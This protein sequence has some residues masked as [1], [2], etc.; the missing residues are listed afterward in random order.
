MTTVFQT[1]PY[2]IENQTILHHTILYICGLLSN[3]ADCES[4]LESKAPDIL[5]ICE[6]SL[7]DLIDS[8]NLSVSG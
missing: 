6:T 4:F 2:G 1:L 5:A 7:D 3:F 8:G